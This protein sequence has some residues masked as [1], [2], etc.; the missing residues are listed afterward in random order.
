MQTRNNMKNV[1]PVFILLWMLCNFYLPRTVYSQTI[2]SSKNLKIKSGTSVPDSK[3][4]TE[5]QLEK[6]GF[7]DIQTLD[8][9][10]KV[11][12]MYARADN[13]TGK[14]LYQDLTRAY[15]HPRAAQA[16][17]QAQ[18]I[19]KSLRPDLSLKVYQK[20]TRAVKFYKREGFQIK[21]ESA[22]QENGEKEYTMEWYS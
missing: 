3:T 1:K 15:L 20:N 4:K 22:D 2:T 18:K 7:V 17:V 21:M 8:S 14:I 9:T 10:I 12:L 13:F 6:A 19:L 16:L 5:I 11:S